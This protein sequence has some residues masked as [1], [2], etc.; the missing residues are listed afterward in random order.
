[1]PPFGRLRDLTKWLIKENKFIILIRIKYRQQQAYN[2]FLEFHRNDI[3]RSY[4]TLFICV[5]I[6]STNISH[7]RCRK[8]F[9]KSLNHQ[10]AKSPNLP[11]DRQ[12]TKSPNRHITTSPIHQFKKSPNQLSQQSPQSHFLGRSYAAYNTKHK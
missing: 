11:T 12:V 10:I 9:F 8:S 7:L 3:L 4:G 2:I 5:Y 6:I 1:M